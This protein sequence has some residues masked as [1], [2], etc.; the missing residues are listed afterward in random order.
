MAYT[1]CVKGFFA[2]ISGRATRS[3]NRLL[4]PN[5][6]LTTTQVDAIHDTTLVTHGQLPES[7]INYTD[8]ISGA[9]FA[10]GPPSYRT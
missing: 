2:V 8:G 5:V 1:K 9:G 6:S 4:P 3:S 10:A 7:S